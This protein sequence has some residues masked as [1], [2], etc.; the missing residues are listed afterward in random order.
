MSTPAWAQASS[1][2]VPLGTASVIPSMVT[3]TF[4]TAA[5]VSSAMAVFLG[6][7]PERG[8]A[9]A[10]H[11]EV[12]GLHEG[13]VVAAELLDAGYDGR[14]RRVAQHADGLARHLV[15]DVQQRVQ[16]VGGAAAHLDALEDL[17]APRRPLA[18]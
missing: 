3:E 6:C 18:A 4:S 15:A 1:R 9:R 10:G 8:S 16:V 17:G 7:V 2:R 12:P 14:R 13:Q 11:G 5:V